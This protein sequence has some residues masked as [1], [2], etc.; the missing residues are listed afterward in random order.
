MSFKRRTTAK[1]TSNP[2]QGT[3]ASPSS[4]ATTIT[5]S[6]V[7]SLDDILGG[8]L[9]LSCSLLV[10]APDEHSAYGELVHKYFIA[11]GIACGQKVCVVDDHAELFVSECMWMPSAVPATVAY[12]EEDGDGQDDADAKVKIAWRYEQM[13]KFQTTVPSNHAFLSRVTDEF[14][15]TFDLTYRIPGHV[16]SEIIKSSR[17]VLLDIQ[18]SDTNG[19]LIT[20][21]IS[22][23]VELLADP[24][25]SPVR[26]CIPSLGSPSWGDL[27]PQDILLFFHLLRNLLRNHPH[28][29][30]AVGLPP[31]ISVDGWGGPGW[32]QKLSWLSDASIT[33]AGFTADPS[34]SSL[35]PSHH[36][37][38]QIHALPAP[39]TLLSPSDKFSALRGISAASASTGG[40]ENN[41]AFKCMRKRLVFETL[42]L[43]VEGGVGERRTTPAANAIA[44]DESAWP[45]EKTSSP[46]NPTRKQAAAAAV[47]VELEETARPPAVA[48]P[49]TATPKPVKTRKKV[50][51]RSD[52][53][54]LYDF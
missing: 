5:S 51:F 52:R 38:V 10:L 30:A 34:L 21:T 20:Q 24:D 28:A 11:Q 40:G 53:P 13:K 46:G 18:G 14:C 1:S 47:V 50:A 16:I 54:D 35:F 41:L 39:H 42:H 2:L 17:L 19:S 8:G 12:A 6:G 36:G 45:S 27:R 4:P 9:P 49:E 44:I 29:C 31:H 3:R 48:E 26:I 7:P 43:D 33:L 22:R 32:T 15:R 37:L 23:I 25:S